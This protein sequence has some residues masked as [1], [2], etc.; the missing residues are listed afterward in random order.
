MGMVTEKS[1]VVFVIDMARD[2]LDAIPH[3]KTHDERI[4][5]LAGIRAY[6]DFARYPESGLLHEHVEKL[7]ALEREAEKLLL[8]YSDV[9]ATNMD[10]H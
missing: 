5:A 10:P 7:E 8:R 2:K 3:M 9:E 6:L 1:T 4:S